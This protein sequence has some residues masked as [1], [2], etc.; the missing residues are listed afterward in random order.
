MDPLKVS[1]KELGSI[2]YPPEKEKTK[3][4]PDYAYIDH[5]LK[6][7]GVTLTL[8]WEEYKMQNPHG[9]MWTLPH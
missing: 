2:I 7:K 5:E 4:E 8:L 1:A 6:K 3:A 9:Y